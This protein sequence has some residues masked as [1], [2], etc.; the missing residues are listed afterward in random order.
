MVEHIHYEFTS[1]L[2]SLENCAAVCGARTHSATAGMV[3]VP[4]IY[5]ELFF[6][7][8]FFSMHNM[9]IRRTSACAQSKIITRT[10]TLALA[11]RPQQHA[12]FHFFCLVLFFFSLFQKTWASRGC[13]IHSFVIFLAAS[14]VHA[15]DEAPRFA[16]ATGTHSIEMQQKK[17]KKNVQLQTYP[18]YV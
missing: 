9:W 3:H 12:Q 6:F 1:F 16:C 17:K 18:T 14:S 15:R 10:F 11:V 5:K 4:Y 8:F 7:S 13:C 2:Y